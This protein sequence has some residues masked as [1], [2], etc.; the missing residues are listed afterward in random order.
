MHSSGLGFYEYLL[1][2]EDLG[3]EPIMAVWAGKQRFPDCVTRVLMSAG[4]SLGGTNLAQNQLGPYIQQAI[5]Q[6]SVALPL[7]VLL[8]SHLIDQFCRRWNEHCPWYVGNMTRRK[9]A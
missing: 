1:W 5:D 2:C 8:V 7:R 3:M 9:P 4:Y 6:V